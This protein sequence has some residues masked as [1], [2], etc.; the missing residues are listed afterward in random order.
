LKVIL[1]DVRSYDRDAFNKANVR[2]GHEL[3]YM[4]T[5]LD[6]STVSLASQFPVVCPFVNDCLN[7]A[8]LERLWANGTRLLA[9]RS[10][11]Y[12]H[13]DVS[14][15]KSLGFRLIRVPEYSPYAVAEHAVGLLLT[16]NRKIHRAV[17]RV[18]EGNF[19][20]EGLVGWDLHGKTCGIIGTGRIGTVMA[21]I[22]HGFGC[23]VLAYDV[24]P[25]AE[26]VSKLSVEYVPL[27]Q[28]YAQADVIS[29]HVPLT[30]HTH[31][32]INHDALAMMKPNVILINTSRGGLIDTRALIAALKSGRIGGAAL[33]VYEE[34]EHYF[35]RDLSDRIIQDDV[36][37]RLLTF[38]NVV[39][40]AHQGF[41]T[42]EALTNIAET[43]LAGITAFEQGKPLPH[44]LLLPDHT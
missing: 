18:R 1:F 20:L 41:L 27:Q 24:Q 5:R 19:S 11:G 16:L 31:H 37:A 2:Y 22:L 28:L 6:L 23:R 13:V 43:T 14:A 7:R 12:N 36:L 33:D 32:I 40:T 17:N 3:V 10:A 44:E 4:D 9:L 26:L 30:P 39:I 38:P 42:Q 29:L 21:H 34:E 35:F 25:N 15:A 8:V